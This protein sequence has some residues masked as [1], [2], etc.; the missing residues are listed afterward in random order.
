MVD[1]KQVEKMIYCQKDGCSDYFYQMADYI[2][3][4]KCRLR[5]G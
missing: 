2:I 5:N 4:P 3:C 1:N